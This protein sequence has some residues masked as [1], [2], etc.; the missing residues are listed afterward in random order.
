LSSFG[1]VISRTQAYQRFNSKPKESKLL[2]F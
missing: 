2:S 1:A